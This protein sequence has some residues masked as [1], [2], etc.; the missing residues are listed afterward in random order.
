[1]SSRSRVPEDRSR[2]VVTLVTRN[3][4]M[5]GNIASSPGPNLSKRSP[6]TSSNIHQSRLISTHGTTSSMASVRW[7]R[8]TWVR[9]RAAT[10][11]VTLGLTSPPP[12]SAGTPPPRRPRGALP[13]VAGCAVGDDPALPHQQQPVAALGLVHHVARDQHCR[14]RRREAVE[15]RPEV[16]SQHGVEAHGG[17][18]EDQQVRSAQQRDSEADPVALPAGEPPDDPVAVVTESDGVDRLVDGAG[19]HPE[20]AGKEGEVLG[21]GQVAVHARRLGDV[22]DPAPQTR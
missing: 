10:A 6:G 18:V 17:L 16:V 12:P 20:H 8:R 1:V 9:T 11:N 7:S 22:A 3:I 5:K 15:E 19:R 13:D 21:D 2:S 4:T 14:T